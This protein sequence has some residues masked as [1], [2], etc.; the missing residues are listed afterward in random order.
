MLEHH[1]MGAPDESSPEAAAEAALR[2]AGYDVRRT[3][4]EGPGAGIL[5]GVRVI[6]TP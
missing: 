5:W 6:P 1:P 4:T 2:D 3:V